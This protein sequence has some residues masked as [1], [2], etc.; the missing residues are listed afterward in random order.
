ML[1]FSWGNDQNCLQEVK[2]EEKENKIR[3]EENSGFLVSLSRSSWVI[4]W[5]SLSLIL[6]SPSNSLPLSFGTF[7]F[8]LSFPLSFHSSHTFRDDRGV[9][10]K[11]SLSQ[12]ESFSCE[13]KFSNK[14]PGDIYSS[15]LCYTLLFKAIMSVTTW[16][17]LLD[18]HDS[19][20]LVYLVS[21]VYLLKMSP[22][23]HILSR[24]LLLPQSLPSWRSISHDTIISPMTV[25]LSLCLTQKTL[26][27]GFTSSVWQ[28][29]WRSICLLLLFLSINCTVDLLLLI[30]LSFETFSCLLLNHITL[31]S[32]SFQSSFFSF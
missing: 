11:E 4:F 6:L 16:I 25:S 19:R 26:V 29:S 32:L 15:Q 8:T 9:I 22:K 12:G 27:V 10:C 13:W 2:R 23:T 30:I 14:C 7:G 17:T 21:R 3:K 18:L 31:L 28:D 1:Y 20:G 5:D 24:V